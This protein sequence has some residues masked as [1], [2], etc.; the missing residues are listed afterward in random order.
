MRRSNPRR[1]A[2][3]NAWSS[4]DVQQLR[5]L[6]QAGVAPEIIATRLRRTH[7][8]IRNK[9]AMHGISLKS[10]SERMQDKICIA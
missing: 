1:S 9:A 7:S 10:G 2:P 8:A 4:E 5:A 6:A 3:G